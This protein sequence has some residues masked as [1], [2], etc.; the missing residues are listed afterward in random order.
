MFFKVL[1]LCLLGVLVMPVHGQDSHDLIKSR[2]AAKPASELEK[3]HA[4]LTAQIQAMVKAA[5]AKNSEI[6]QFNHQAKYGKS[7]KS[8]LIRELHAE[9]KML[10]Q[11]AFQKRQELNDAIMQVPEAKKLEDE[12]REIFKEIAR[13][14]NEQRAVD[15]ELQRAR[16]MQKE[17]K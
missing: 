5:N 15:N 17:T 2:P 6:T 4:E 8:R 12:R 14:K 1:L 3:K 9:V 16:S 10:E 11:K 13:L 7:E